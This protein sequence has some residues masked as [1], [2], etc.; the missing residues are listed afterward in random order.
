MKREKLSMQQL[1]RISVEEFKRSEKLNIRV[2]LDNVRSMNNVGSVFRT[3]DAFLIDRLYLCGIT[4]RPPHREIQKTA[5]GATESVDWTYFPQTVQAL[6]ELRKEDYT[7]YA[8]EQT[9]DS[10]MLNEFKPAKEEKIA[11]IMGNEVEGVS[12][13]AL[14]LC[15]KVVEIPQFGTKHSLNVSTSCAIVLWQIVSSVKY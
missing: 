9:T 10:I 7:I 3:S 1:H 4:P 15:D 14:E 13:S 12:Q 2:V 11:V 6:E 5:L 8:V